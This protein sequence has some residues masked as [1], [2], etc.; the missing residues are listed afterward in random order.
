MNLYNTIMSYFWLAVA[1][2]SFVAV[3]YYCI[4]EGFDKYAS[5]Y[6]FSIVAI[7]TYFVKKWMM[8]RMGN[9]T[10]HMQEQDNKK[11]A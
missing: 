2:V 1:A 6:I 9:H 8:K 4:T 5:N 10:K 11:E 3:T 7:S